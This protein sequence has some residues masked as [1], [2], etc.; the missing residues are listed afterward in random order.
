MQFQWYKVTFYK[1]IYKN[2]KH[3]KPSEDGWLKFPSQGIKVLFTWSGS[4][5]N[6]NHNADLKDNL[7]KDSICF[8]YEHLLKFKKGTVYDESCR[9][10]VD[11]VYWRKGKAFEIDETIDGESNMIVI[12]EKMPDGFDPQQQHPVPTPTPSIAK[13]TTQIWSFFEFSW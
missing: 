13:V 1:K 5:S 4:S 8:S 11:Q 3:R 6:Y 9:Q 10:Q 2:N 7:N 12:E